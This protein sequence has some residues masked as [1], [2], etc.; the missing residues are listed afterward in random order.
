[1]VEG[2]NPAALNLQTLMAKRL[3]LPP[4]WHEQER[5]LMIAQSSSP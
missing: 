2:R 4:T 1:M 5:L 3:I